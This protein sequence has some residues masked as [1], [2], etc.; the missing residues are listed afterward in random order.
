MPVGRYYSNR[1]QAS[2]M[3]RHQWRRNG[4]QMGSCPPTLSVC[5]GGGGRPGPVREDGYC[6]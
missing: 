4:G 1:A 5:V 2:E 3:E 6:I